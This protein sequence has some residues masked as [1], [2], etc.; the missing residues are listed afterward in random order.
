MLNSKIPLPQRSI[1]SSG[2]D[3]HSPAATHTS[4]TNRS[5]LTS[6][7]S[8]PESG[9]PKS[10]IP[11]PSGSSSSSSSNGSSP[12]KKPTSPSKIPLPV[13]NE[14]QP[15]RTMRKYE[16]FVMTGERMLCIS[17][18]PAKAITKSLPASPLDRKKHISPLEEDDDDDLKPFK[19]QTS[20]VSRTPEPIISAQAVAVALHHS[21]DLDESISP[22]PTEDRL[23]DNMNDSI[24]SSSSSDDIEEVELEVEHYDD[25]SLRGPSMIPFNGGG[26]VQDPSSEGESDL[27]SLHSYHPPPKIVDVPSAIRLAK[28]LYQLDGFRKSDVSRHL[29]RN[30]EYNQVVAEDQFCL[31]GETQERERVLFYF[32]KRYMECNPECKSKFL[33]SDAVHTLTCAYHAS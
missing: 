12:T 28:R 15:Q 20:R 24:S 6:S 8:S 14:V 3:Y 13:T 27:E 1:S 19:T 25:A 10:R 22:S 30:N 32:S 31:T 11:L 29:S 18:T 21:L 7:L 17:K 26:G 4:T 33:S 5:P 9:F 2:L 23:I 16:T